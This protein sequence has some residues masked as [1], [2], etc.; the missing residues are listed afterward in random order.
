MLY[1]ILKEPSGGEDSVGPWNTALKLQ[2]A[3]CARLT[4][5]YLP[6]QGAARALC[7][8]QRPVLPQL[9]TQVPLSQKLLNREERGPYEERLLDRESRE[10]AARLSQ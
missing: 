2:S 5:R 8:L 3:R 9:L 4:R 7:P 1:L 6:S 10:V